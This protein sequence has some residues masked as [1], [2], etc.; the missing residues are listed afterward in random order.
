MP[1]ESNLR[2]E[3]SVAPP[4][5]PTETKPITGRKKA[6]AT[7]SRT[8]C[9]T[10]RKRH[11]KCD[12]RVPACERCVVGK[13]ECRYGTLVPR[14]GASQDTRAEYSEMSEHQQTRLETRG[15]RISVEAEP[16]DWDYM[17]T[18]RYYFE[19]VRPMRPSKNGRIVDP[20]FTL[21]EATYYTTKVVSTHISMVAKGCGRPLEYGEI[22]A[23]GPMWA[24]YSRYLLKVI[25]L[26]HSY[27]KDTSPKSVVEVISNMCLLLTA[28]IGTG[29]TEWKAHTDGFYAYVQRLGGVQVIL[30]LSSP[31]PWI[32]CQMFHATVLYNTTTPALRHCLGYDDWTDEQLEI[33]LL[34][35]HQIIPERA[36]P[37][38]QMIVLIHLTRLRY[39]IA[40]SACD[41]PREPLA[42]VIDAHYQKLHS[43]D[44]DGWASRTIGF[45][46]THHKALAEIHRLAIWL[47]AILTLPRPAVLQWAEAE[48]SLQPYDAETNAYDRVR[49]LYRSKLL[50]SIRGLFHELKYPRAVCW[51]LI[52]AGVAAVDG[53]AEDRAF[54][55]DCI[56]SVWLSPH[57]G[58]GLF[59]SLQKLRKFW[60][61]GRTGW[62][63]CFYEP[64]PC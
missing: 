11:M 30:D 20:T 45:G 56:Y 26:I 63:D 59:P 52:V 60:D 51:A 9:L 25:D 34:H 36:F 41:A 62:E 7:R 53:T 46:T 23:L 10:C 14:G 49:A 33:L 15:T 1:L 48:I 55:D 58:G 50:R 16:P 40:T 28:D 22:K 27:F 21:N 3:L 24:T 32:F 18:I 31:P 57:G 35:G 8:G 61:T 13:R 38:L 39:K 64:T 44:E 19:I 2:R 37:T 29:S 12:E 5:D 43:I 47:Y 17:Q 4:I 54:V 6:W 42:A